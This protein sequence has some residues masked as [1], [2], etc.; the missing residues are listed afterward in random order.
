[1]D[2]IHAEIAAGGARAVAQAEVG[3]ARPDSERLIRRAQSQMRA[4]QSPAL[5]IA[6]AFLI[7]AGAFLHSH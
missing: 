6:V 1:L 3:T 2:Q 7:G 5:I 4:L